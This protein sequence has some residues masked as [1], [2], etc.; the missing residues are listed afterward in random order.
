VH[1]YLKGKLNSIS[2]LWL[3]LAF[4]LPLAAVLVFAVKPVEAG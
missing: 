1:T 3:L 2:S 4:V